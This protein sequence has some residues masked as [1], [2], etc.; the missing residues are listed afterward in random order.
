LG[1]PNASSNCNDS[2]DFNTSIEI[3]DPATAGFQTDSNQTFKAEGET[4]TLLAD[5]SALITQGGQGLFVDADGSCDFFVTNAAA[6]FQPTSGGFPVIQFTSMTQER[7]GASA[8]LLQDGKVLV[9]G[10]DGGGPI[11]Q[12]IQP[13]ASAELYNPATGRFSVT[14]SMA[15]AREGHEATLLSNGKVLVAGGT[16]SFDTLDRV[17]ATAEL[18]DPATGTFSPTGS[19]TTPRALFTATLLPNGK[20][21]VSGGNDN[22]GKVLATAEL[23]DPTAGTFTLT[24]SMAV[25]RS[26]HTATLLPN[27][28][29]LAVGGGDTS[30][31]LAT[32]ELYDPAT[33]T[34]SFTGGLATARAS[35]TATLLQTGE[36]LVIGGVN[37]CTS[38]G[39]VILASAEI[40]K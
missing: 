6:L 8:T 4:G 15:A 32:A 39:C 33:G 3:F 11:F 36:V 7:E 38:A 35:H 19:M 16:L 2:A 1:D 25:P 29:V 10:G 18:Y 34:F 27:G 13:V 31:L 12:V 17:T 40:Y 20:V 14:G 5:G 9:A 24:G 28:K 30:G 23:Y 26:G 22:L 21:L 37:N